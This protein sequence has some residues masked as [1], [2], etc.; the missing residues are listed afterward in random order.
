MVLINN[1]FVIDFQEMFLLY[2]ISN[3]PFV[4]WPGLEVDQR[5]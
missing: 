4:E 2:R 1:D 3:F 5:S